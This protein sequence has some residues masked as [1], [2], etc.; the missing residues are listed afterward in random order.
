[1]AEKTSGSQSWLEKGKKEIHCVKC[2]SVQLHFIEQLLSSRH[3]SRYWS[4]SGKQ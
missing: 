2:S 1:M 3:C 4:Y